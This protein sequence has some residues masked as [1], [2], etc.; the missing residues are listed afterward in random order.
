MHEYMYVCI[1]CAC[2]YVFCVHACIMEQCIEG[3]KVMELRAGG[4]YK[5]FK[6]IVMVCEVIANMD[7]K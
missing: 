6:E 3:L 4:A 1:L 5:A 2:L 7:L